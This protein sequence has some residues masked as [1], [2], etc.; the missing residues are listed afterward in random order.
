MATSPSELSRRC[1]PCGSSSAFVAGLPLNMTERKQAPNPRRSR[2]VRWGARTSRRASIHALAGGTPT[3]GNDGSSDAGLQGGNG[4][5]PHGKNDF[6]EAGSTED[7]P[8][9]RELEMLWRRDQFGKTFPAQSTVNTCSECTGSGAVEC[10][11]C[12]ATGVLM[13]GD[14]IICSISGG[15]TCPVCEGHG[16]TKCRRC[17]GSGNVASWIVD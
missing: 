5:D 17:S 8:G 3:G 7:A 9:W 2:F 13:L 14:K 12:S 15:T 6:E 11:F 16:E 1:D 4:K 10:R